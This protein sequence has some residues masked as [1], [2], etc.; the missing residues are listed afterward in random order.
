MEIAEIRQ[1]IQ[2]GIPECE[3]IVAGEGCSFS[4]VVIGDSFAGLS[5]VKRQQQVLATISAPLSTG[6]LHA[7]SMRV[8][9][10]SEWELEQEQQAAGC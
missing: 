6:E 3:L 10:P 8:Y 7:I 5:R 4:V 1:L 9:T 2:A